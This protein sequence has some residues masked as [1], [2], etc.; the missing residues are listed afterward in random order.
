MRSFAP[1][2]V[3]CF[4]FVFDI[5]VYKRIIITIIIITKYS[6]KGSPD[7]IPSGWLRSKHQLTN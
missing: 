3:L 5:A 1:S 4:V 6:W 7:I 2:C